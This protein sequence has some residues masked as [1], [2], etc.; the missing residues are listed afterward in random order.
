MVN[1]FKSFEL[2]INLNSEQVLGRIKSKTISSNRISPS[3]VEFKGEFYKNHF[4]LQ[5]KT[6]GNIW[7]MNGINPEFFGFV[8]NKDSFTEL[9]VKMRIHPLLSLVLTIP[10]I[11]FIIG[12]INFIYSSDI[13]LLLLTSI[14]LISCTTIVGSIL[15]DKYNHMK[16]ILG[17]LFYKELI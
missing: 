16:T 6:S 4:K 15:N 7:V 13:M 9:S 10:I 11:M 14:T 12:I 8:K 3:D 17:K 5:F 2:K 1:I